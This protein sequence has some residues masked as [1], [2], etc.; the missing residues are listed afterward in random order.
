MLVLSAATIITTKSGDHA[1][2]LVLAQGVADLNSDMHRY[3]MPRTVTQEQL[4]KMVAFLLKYPPHKVKIYY[5]KNS[6]E[7][8]QYAGACLEYSHG[9]LGMEQEEC[10]R[11]IIY[12]RASPFNLNLQHL[13]I[14]ALTQGI[15]RRKLLTN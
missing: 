2:V 5:A 10:G 13:Q 6:D 11:R 1:K 8:L 7:A 3:A 12:G 15:Q 9:E 14:L 4:D